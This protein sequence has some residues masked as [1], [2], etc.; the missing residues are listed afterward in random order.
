[1]QVTNVCRH[2]PGISLGPRKATEITVFEMALAALLATAAW[3]GAG[4]FLLWIPSQLVGV[5]PPLFVFGELLGTFLGIYCFW[6][7]ANVLVDWAHVFKL[8]F[9]TCRT[10]VS[11]ATAIEWPAKPGY[12][13]LESW[14]PVLDMAASYYYSLY[15]YQRLPKIL[16][17]AWLGIF[18]GFVMTFVFTAAGALYALAFTA[19]PMP[20]FRHMFYPA[21]FWLLLSLELLSVWLSVSRRRAL[22]KHWCALNPSRQTSPTKQDWQSAQINCLN[23][24][25]PPGMDSPF[26]VF[27]WARNQCASDITKPTAIFGVAKPFAVLITALLTG[28]RFL[29]RLATYGDFHASI[30]LWVM[31]LPVLLALLFFWILY[32]LVSRSWEADMYYPPCWFYPLR[33]MCRDIMDLYDL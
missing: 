33:V 9:R 17:W 29:P 6:K 20:W 8:A 4:F 23:H 24:Y 19:H 22:K 28:V 3:V 26:Q 10:T 30:Y 16:K 18:L 15:G 5:S 27:Q 12:T 31:V 1:M 13:S 32:R 25:L 7:G 21:V 11:R 2:R 14:K